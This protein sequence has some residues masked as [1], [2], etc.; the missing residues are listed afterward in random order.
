MARVD[1]GL[2][3]GDKLVEQVVGLH[4]VALAAADFDERALL[5]LVG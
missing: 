3:G 2:R 1:L 5:V 4:A